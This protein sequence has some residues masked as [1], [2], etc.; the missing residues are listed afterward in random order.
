MKGKDAIIH[1]ESRRYKWV[2]TVLE[3]T[4]HCLSKSEQNKLKQAFFTLKE[5]N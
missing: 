4:A 5:L 1:K 3:K 2:Q